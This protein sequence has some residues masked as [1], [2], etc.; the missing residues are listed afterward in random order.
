MPCY[1]I[2]ISIVI[3]ISRYGSVLEVKGI[4]LLDNKLHIDKKPYI[5][6]FDLF[7]GASGRWAGSKSWRPE[8]RG[9]E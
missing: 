6:G 1:S 8:P 2:G 4:D 5:L 7:C 3:L 9:Y